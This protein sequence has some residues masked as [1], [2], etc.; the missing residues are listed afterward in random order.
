MGSGKRGRRGEGSFPGSPDGHITLN[1][2]G[3]GHIPL[4]PLK[5][6]RLETGPRSPLSRELTPNTHPMNG[7]GG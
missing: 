6:M 7:G 2:L 3:E 4:Q 5:A 1:V